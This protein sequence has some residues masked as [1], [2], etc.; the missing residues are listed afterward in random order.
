MYTTVVHTHTY[1]QPSPAHLGGDG[2]DLV[3]ELAGRLRGRGLAV[4]G[5]RERVLRLAVDAKLGR[6]VLRRHAHRHQAAL[7]LSG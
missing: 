4:A 1:V 6:H 3:A 2:H 7:G 5:R